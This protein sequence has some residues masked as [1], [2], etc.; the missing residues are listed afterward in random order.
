MAESACGTQKGKASN[1]NPI[2]T[3]DPDVSKTNSATPSELKAKENSEIQN[4]AS[5]RS[6]TVHRDDVQTTQRVKT[7]P[8]N[9]TNHESG[10]EL[11]EPSESSEVKPEPQPEWPSNIMAMSLPKSTL[12]LDA[13]D[14]HEQFRLFKF[15]HEN[16]MT[17][18]NISATNTAAR[19]AA[20]KLDL[21]LEARRII[22]N[23]DWTKNGKDKDSIDDIIAVLC[24]AKRKKSSKILA[25]NKFHNRV[26]QKRER[27]ADYKQTL[28]MLIDQCGYPEEMRETMVRDQII[29]GHHDEALRR[30]M[31][32]LEDTATLAQVSEICETHEDTI[33]AAKELARPTQQSS[34]TVNDKKKNRDKKNDSQRKP[35]TKGDAKN[36]WRCTNFC[37][38]RHMR[39]HTNCPAY[40]T[41]CTKCGRKNHFEEVCRKP[42]L[43]GWVP[44]T[45]AAEDHHR[46]ML[47]EHVYEVE[48]QSHPYDEEQRSSRSPTPGKGYDTETDAVKS[49]SSDSE[50]QIPI[51]APRKVKVTA[52]TLKVTTRSQS[53]LRN[54]LEKD[55]RSPK[56][57]PRYVE[58]ISEAVE[59]QI[60]DKSDF[61][62]R[63]ERRGRQDRSPRA[64]RK[65]SRSRNRYSESPQQ[66]RS[67]RDEAGPSKSMAL[68]L[69]ETR[70]RTKPSTTQQRDKV[71]IKSEVQRPKPKQ[72]SPPATSKPE[73]E[74][75]YELSD[76]ELTNTVSRTNRV[77]RTWDE[78]LNINGRMAKFKVDSGST[79]NTLSLRVF[80][81]LGL[82]EEIINPTNTTIRTYSENVMQPL[83]EFE[84][85]VTLR[86]RRSRA[87]FLLMDEDVPSLLGMPT[88]AA[89]G[90]FHIAKNSIIQWLENEDEEY[91]FD[92][93]DAICD[94]FL[95]PCDKTVEI[96]LKPGAKPVSVPPRRVPLALKNE[97]HEELLRMQRM[98][99]ITPV[100]EPRP[101]CHA[102]VVAR[103]PNGKLR[104]CIDPRTLNPWI[105]REE[106]MIPDIDNLIVNLDEAKIMTLLDLEAG[107]WQVG[108]DQ[109]S[110]KLLTFATPWGR[111]QYNR[112][113]YGISTAAEIFHKAVVDALQDI[114]GV[115]VYVDDVLT[116]GKDVPEH[117]D[118]VARVKA[119]L[120]ERGFTTNKAKSKE[121]VTRVKFLGHIIGEGQIIPDPDKIKAIL[122]Y[123]EPKCRKELKGFQGM[124]SWLRKFVPTINSLLNDFRPLMKAHTAWTWTA[125]ESETFTKIKTAIKEI[126]P[127]MAIKPGE[128]LTLA[129]DASSFGLGAALTQKDKDGNERPVF[130][131][132]RLMTDTEI[133]YAQIDKELLALVWAMER[134]D[135]LIYGQRVTVHTDHKPLLGLFKKPMAYMSPRQQR[136]ISR[137]MRYD[138]ELCYVPGRELVVADALSRSASAQGPVCRCTMMGTDILREEAFVSMLEATDLP[139][140]ITTSVTLLMDDTYREAMKACDEGWPT[141]AKALTGEYWSA[142]NEMTKERD[143][144][145]YDGRLVIPKG[146]R[147]HVL[148]FLHR[149][150]VGAST[151]MKRAEKTVWWPGLRN[152]A[153]SRV[154]KCGDCLKC[155]PAQRREPML[156]FTVPDSPG[157]VI[158]A[159][160]F[161]WAARDYLILVDGMSGWTEAFTMRNMRPAELKRAV[162]AYM[163]RNG[164]PEVFH[165]DQGSTFES[166]EFQE[167]CQQWSIRFSDNSA[168]YPRGNAI[169]E[170]HVKKMKHVIMT[171]KDDDDLARAV[172]AMM[173]TPVAPGQ[174]SPSELHLGRCVR[175]E[176][177]PRVQKYE[178]AWDEFRVWKQMNAEQQARYYN[179]GTRAL[180]PLKAG[181]DVMIWHRDEWHR[182]TVEACLT[183]P[184]SYPTDASDEVRKDANPYS[185]FQQTLQVPPHPL[186]IERR[187]EE[188][189]TEADEPDDED[190]PDS[191]PDHEYHEAEEDLP[192][193]ESQSES[194]GDERD[195]DDNAEEEEDHTVSTDN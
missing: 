11:Q 116:Y 137:T 91:E 108:V 147:K 82:R 175:D 87:R 148:E 70:S 102:M 132:S 182:G 93:I 142:R 140:D 191:D 190:D 156:S 127:L 130:F 167:F 101:W 85:T 139:S 144:M 57:P 155:M 69:H 24:D 153:R 174:P 189:R 39:G 121:S 114:P 111:F 152:E 14:L 42:P 60:R 179:R 22:M 51:P 32:Q 88:G 117:D 193:Y 28:L 123:P 94:E 48:D 77:P 44:R 37:G 122:D 188:P 90:L 41:T 21:P 194:E 100:E 166:R 173:Q 180:E 35:D 125:T 104:I 171:A 6:R 72:L 15:E 12:D 154:Q 124:I 4:E 45:K 159:D 129:A 10:V 177:H 107:F 81:K 149:G 138:F 172:L 158:H 145:F 83:G 17:L 170:A 33:D 50:Q 181:D 92:G 141:S 58:V 66:H 115:I 26:M 54:A 19:A 67:R 112:L 150:H 135:P 30:Q 163:M 131:A 151:M 186:R 49:D 160:Y 80:Q 59:V 109:E 97:V 53:D 61:E 161:E 84:A 2:L 99:V 195:D 64:S 98:G 176:I 89:L 184:R 105:E 118:R 120:E 16:K 25:K 55:S 162:R 185:L 128:K 169:A 119:R 52:G 95:K 76:E 164:V 27:F 7:E 1:S 133:K 46:K 73:D 3:A 29:R 31:L 86:G 103:K 34:N 47:A 113:P 136:L 187:Q 134:L 5:A 23:T 96:K 8:E 13:D 68:S 71:Q 36:L 110:A 192:E 146:A 143:V 38:G 63:Y 9:E 74:L 75:N 56:R 178:G 18:S 157:Q 106:M 168:K 20:F 79:V 165:T 43:L 183:R 40:N 62:H 78:N 126:Q 65:R